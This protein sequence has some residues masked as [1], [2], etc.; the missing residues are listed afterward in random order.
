MGKLNKDE[1]LSGNFTYGFFEGEKLNSVV[2]AGTDISNNKVATSVIGAIAITICGTWMFLSTPSMS[3]VET[4]ILTPRSS[5]IMTTSR[6]KNSLSNIS[7]SISKRMTKN[8]RV[9]KTTEIPNLSG[10]ITGFIAYN[11]LGTGQI[12][13]EE[14]EMRPIRLEKVLVYG[15][16]IALGLSSLT[17][18]TVTNYIVPLFDVNIASILTPM[19]IA[20]I[21]M[22]ML[23]YLFRG[24]EN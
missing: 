13:E 18:S 7:G 20:F 23:D 11:T 17:L 12:S 15:S 5:I 9:G 6:N 21:L 4:R 1:P 16:L 22:V 8:H 2:K 3:S 10:N 14:A 19:S 24:R